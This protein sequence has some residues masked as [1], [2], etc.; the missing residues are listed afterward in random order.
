MMD[1]GGFSVALFT[2]FK[3]IN[4]LYQQD[5]VSYYFAPKFYR[6]PEIYRYAHAE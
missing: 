4:W 2:I 1:L 5:M 6:K 3:L